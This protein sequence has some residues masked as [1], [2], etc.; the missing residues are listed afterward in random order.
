MTIL[1]ILFLRKELIKYNR[2]IIPESS[3]NMMINT[4]K[5]LDL[6]YVV[7]RKNS[8]NHIIDEINKTSI[9]KSQKQSI[10]NKLQKMNNIKV[11]YFNGKQRRVVARFLF[12]KIEINADDILFDDSQFTG[13]TSKNIGLDGVYLFKF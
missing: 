4:C 2:I 10:I 9:Q 13:T 7:V 8:I 11:N 5:I 6:N 1:S 12:E 3:N